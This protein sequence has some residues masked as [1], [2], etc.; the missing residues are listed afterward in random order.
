MNTRE[1]RES[2]VHD[3]LEEQI[4]REAYLLWQKEGRPPGRELEHWE[5]AREL[6]RHRAPETAAAGGRPGDEP[7]LQETGAVEPG[8]AEP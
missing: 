3:R 7:V 4:R 5:A 6:V 1:H 8:A 2:V